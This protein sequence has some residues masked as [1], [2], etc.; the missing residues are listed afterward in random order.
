[1]HNIVKQKIFLY[2]NHTHTNI[3]PLV[4]SIDEIVNTCRTKHI[5]YNC[6]GT[7]LKDSIIACQQAKKYSDTIRC[8][9]GIHP[10]ECNDLNDIHAIEKLYLQNKEHIVAIGEIGLDYYGINKDKEK[11][12]HFFK[13]LIE[14]ANKYA[15]PM[16]IHVRDA[17]LDCLELLQNV[18]YPNKV[19]IHCFTGDKWLAKKYIERGYVISVSGIVTFKNALL[20]HEAI[21]YIPLDKMLVETDGPWLSPYPYRG[22]TNYPYY[23]EYV[24]NNIANRLNIDPQELFKQLVENTYNFYQIS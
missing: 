3:S 5:I 13:L 9:V 18:K 1:M 11:Q 6:V 10:D 4:E 8:M 23:V 7:N 19:C 22:K 24:A 12:K 20:L 2:D 16:C 15:L 17:E 21:K 14:L